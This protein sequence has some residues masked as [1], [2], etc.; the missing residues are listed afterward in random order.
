MKRLIALL[1]ALTL[2]LGAVP[3]MAATL[4]EKFGGQLTEQGFRGTVTFSASGS[5]TAALN[6]DA[7]NWLQSAASRVTL[8]VHHSLQDRA[9][10]QW[11]ADVLIDGQA[12]AKTTYLYN[13]SLA[14]V[15]SDL[16]AGHEKAWY[17]AARSWD[18]SALIKNIAQP[19]SEWPPIWH[20]LTEIENAPAAWKEKASQHFVL[21]ETKLGSWLN[22]YAVPSTGKENKVSYTQLQWRIPADDVKAEIKAL[23]A[24]FFS[25]AQML[26]LLREIVTAQEAASY[27]QPGLLSSLQRMVDRVS[28]K[29]EI[30]ITRRYNASGRAILDQVK[31]P[32]A[33]NQFLSDLTVTLTPAS[34]GDTWNF[35]GSTRNGADFDITCLTEK[36]HISSGSVAI[37]LP[38]VEETG[39]FLI[40]ESTAERR[41]IAFDFNFTWEPGTEAYS[42]ATDRFTQ[43]MLATLVIKPHNQALPAQSLT[44]QADF[45]SA[46]DAR[47][48]TRVE[49][50]L[51]W[52]DLDGDAAIVASLSGRT[53]APTA[54]T[55]LSD[56]KDAVRLDRLNGSG[57]EKLIQEWKDHLTAWVQDAAEQLLPATLPADAPVIEAAAEPTTEPAQAPTAEPAAEPTLAPT[58]KP[59]ARPAQVQVKINP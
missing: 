7:W 21:Y 3:A 24:D 4:L 28:L 1:L 57:Y 15:T 6:P 18:V 31:L 12:A 48:V 33:E 5:Q 53:A 23:L 14:G 38:P 51:T 43:T 27:L 59:T 9:D 29:G 39:N 44:M 52:R 25:D 35:T 11:T 37:L 55:K 8:D 56:V 54:V 42:L 41:K 50:T 20:V 16:L 13:D 49:A 32:F 34:S 46:S 17:T 36:E 47:A 26:S 40:V 19:G 30:E 45:S 22:A 2:A 58:A 10:G